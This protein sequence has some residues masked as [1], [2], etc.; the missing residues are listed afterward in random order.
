MLKAFL[1]YSTLVVRSAIA[2][3]TKSTFPYMGQILTSRFSSSVDTATT[4]Y[5]TELTTKHPVV[6]FSKSYCPHCTSAKDLVRSASFSSLL[7]S[8]E[9]VFVS[10]LD[11]VENGQLLQDTLQQMTGQ[12]TV[13]NVFV[14]GGHLGGN[15]SLQ[16]AWRSGE[17]KQALLEAT[18]K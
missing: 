2:F 5:I 11:Q 3:Q 4:S 13:P 12:R 10:E 18:K 9:S 16:A 8:P 17:L 1:V 14:N 15:D 7:P 6:V